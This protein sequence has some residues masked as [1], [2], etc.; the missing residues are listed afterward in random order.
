MRRLTKGT[1]MARRVTYSQHGGP[2]VLELV[3]AEVPEPGP[4]QV[5]VRVQAAGLNPVDWKIFTAASA[6]YASELPSGNGNDFA[7]VVDAIGEGVVG[8]VVGDSVFGGARHQAQADYLLATPDTLLHRPEGLS[9]EQ[10]A[11]LDIAGRTALASVAAVGVGPGDVVFVSA[12]AGGVGVLAAQLSVRAGA[13]V[14]GT[15]SESNHDYLRSLGVI[16][17]AYGDGMVERLRDAAPAPFTA[18]LDNNGRASIDAARALGVPVERI[19]TIADR[20]AVAEYGITA[21]G[22]GAASVA[23]LKTLAD[24]IASGEIELPIDSTYPLERV[25]AAYEHLMAGHLRGKV[26]LTLQ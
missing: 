23:D 10:A 19:N 21:V 15:A 24:R 1:T 22:G 20:S 4:G 26:V 12:A 2:E 13:T 6:M 17:V 7:G 11:C 16:P 9:L 3:E 14:V 5:R 8:F 18:A 25:R